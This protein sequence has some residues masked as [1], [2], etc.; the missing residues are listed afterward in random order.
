MSEN[1][2]GSV[3]TLLVSPQC[4][5][6]LSIISA[7]PSPWILMHMI[8]NTRQVLLEIVGAFKREP[9]CIQLSSQP[10][11]HLEALVWCVWF[12]FFSKLI[13]WLTTFLGF[14]VRLLF[15][16]RVRKAAAKQIL[17]LLSD[18]KTSRLQLEERTT[19]AWLPNL[20]CVRNQLD[21]SLDSSGKSVLKVEAPPTCDLVRHSVLP[22]DAIAH[23]AS[24]PPSPGWVGGEAVLHLV[25]RHGGRPFEEVG[26]RADHCRTPR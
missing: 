14:S 23:C 22:R 18:N 10:P 13:N 4:A 15:I 3:A 1:F 26:G 11:H 19:A 12:F 17:P 20:Y 25:F 5:S 8:M 9:G 24:D 6:T 21:V 2:I 16:Y 7:S